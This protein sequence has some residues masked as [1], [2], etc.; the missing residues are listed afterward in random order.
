ML[1]FLFLQHNETTLETGLG[2]ELMSLFY[3]QTLW[4]LDIININ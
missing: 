2:V 1:K 3:A 4:L